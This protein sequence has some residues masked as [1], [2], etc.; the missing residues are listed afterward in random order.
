MSKNTTGQPGK[1][2]PIVLIRGSSTTGN[3]SP[4]VVVDGVQGV[5][6]WQRI[7]P[8]D[9]ESISVLKDASAAIYGSRAANGVILITTKRGT[10]GKP[11]ISY[12][13]NFGFSQPTRLPKP[14][15]QPSCWCM[16]RS[17]IPRAGTA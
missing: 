11:T 15:I 5:S 3:N 14:P 7:N 2:D 9:I 17:P 10:T 4:L 12:S 16:A 8:N 13:A 1:D 6:G